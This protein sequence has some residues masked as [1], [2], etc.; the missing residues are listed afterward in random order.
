[1]SLFTLADEHQRLLE[2][3]EAL[4]GRVA[5]LLKE[6]AYLADEVAYL[7]GCSD[8]WRTRGAKRA[9]LDISLSAFDRHR[10]AKFGWGTR[11]C[12]S[13]SQMIEIGLVH[14]ERGI[15]MGAPSGRWNGSTQTV[16]ETS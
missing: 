9:E 8:G 5:R 16:N 4:R 1:M 7:A 2:H 3:I 6:R 12:L 14:H 11:T 13:R 10:T 15:W